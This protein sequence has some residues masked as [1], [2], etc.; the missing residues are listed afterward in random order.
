MMMTM[1]MMMMMMMIV[2][3]CYMNLCKG[4]RNVYPVDAMKPYAGT[5][6]V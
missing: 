6:E 4:K 5:V 1:M 2:Y 3:N